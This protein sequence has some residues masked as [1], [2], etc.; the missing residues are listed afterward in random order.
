[1]KN[2][3]VQLFGPPITV[4]VRAGSARKRAL[5]DVVHDCL[6]QCLARVPRIQPARSVRNIIHQVKLTLMI[7]PI[8]FPDD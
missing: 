1:M 4:P 7:V 3:K 5:G 2:L 8:G 6:L